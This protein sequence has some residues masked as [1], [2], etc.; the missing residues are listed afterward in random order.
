MFLD[1]L[2]GDAI[3]YLPLVECRCDGFRD[4]P[5]VDRNIVEV[6]FVIDATYALENLNRNVL[7]A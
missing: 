7:L 3:Q 4:A 2:Q 5:S 1:E 6:L